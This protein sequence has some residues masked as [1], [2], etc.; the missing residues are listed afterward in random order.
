MILVT[1]AT[2]NVG[3]ELTAALLSAGQQV[4]ALV[5]DEG[6]RLPAGAEPV[7]GDLNDPAGLTPA[8]SGADGLFLMSGYP[9]ASGLLSAAS[10]AGVQRVVLLSGGA[11]V[12]A[13][14]DN[15]ISQYM[16]GT[17][18]AVRDSGLAWTILRP[19]EFMS[20]ALRWVPQAAAG[21]VITVPFAGVPVAVIDPHDIAAVAAAALTSDGEQHAG[22]SYRLSGPTALLP[23]DRVQIL[24]DALGRPLRADAQ[25]DAAARE[26]MLVGTPAS[27]VD[28][29]FDFYTGGGL[30]E[31][32]VLPT[33]QQ[34]TGRPP[35]SFAEWAHDHT[36]AF[37]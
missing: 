2:G 23:A 10:Q 28:A 11:A 35:R 29:F 27:Y 22:Q 1:G 34:V 32:T 33:V 14:T 8:L 13:R 12:A 25:P 24:G 31:S 21:D 26:E 19:Y 3:S 37:R 9:D 15:P 20:N 5:R 16:L 6:A 17:E 7:V 18:R 4:R 36:A 30:D